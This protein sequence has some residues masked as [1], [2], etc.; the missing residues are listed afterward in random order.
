MR[1]ETVTPDTTRSGFTV[2][3]GRD[4]Y[5]S[6]GDRALD[7]TVL[8]GGVEEVAGIASGTTLTGGDI[9]SS[10]VNAAE[11]V[12]DSGGVTRNLTIDAGGAALVVAGGHANGV[13]IG[14]GGQFIAGAGSY[15]GNITVERGGEIQI[16]NDAHVTG[17]TLEKGAREVRDYEV[18]DGVTLSGGNVNGGGFVVVDSGGLSE[19]LSVGISGSLEV[20]SGGEVTGAVIRPGGTLVVDAGAQVDAYVRSGTTVD[21]DTVPIRQAASAVVSN[22]ELEL[23]ASGGKVL[24]AIGLD[25]GGYSKLTFTV[26]SDAYGYAEVQVGPAAG[27][28]SLTQAAAAFGGDQAAPAASAPSPEGGRGGFTLATAPLSPHHTLAR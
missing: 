4:V 12:V 14:S 10:L 11:Q 23:L 18:F 26:A 13:T 8:A 15:D 19:D 2:S 16:Y 6:A 22:G 5:V 24:G 17:L 9:T 25:G 21:F 27:T 20:Y 7:S 1:F 3:S 28:A